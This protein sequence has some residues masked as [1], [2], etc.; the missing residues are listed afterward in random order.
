MFTIDYVNNTIWTPTLS[1][2]YSC[3]PLRMCPTEGT[4]RYDRINNIR[5]LCSRI[6][7]WQVD[8][9]YF[10]HST[11][12]CISG[13][14]FLLSFS[15]DSHAAT[16]EKS[17]LMIEYATVSKGPG[18][19]CLEIATVRRMDF[20]GGLSNPVPC[21]ESSERSTIPLDITRQVCLWVNNR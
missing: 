21:G 17:Y 18:C 15:P 8:H 13:W 1:D 16:M 2:D 11:L 4:T 9:F 14:R 7:I 12:K 10:R 6:H 5:I 19:E 3:H 20:V